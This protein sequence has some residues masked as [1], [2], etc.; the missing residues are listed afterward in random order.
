M[1]EKLSRNFVRKRRHDRL[2]KKLRG[3]S[4]CPR[5]SVYRSLKNVYAQLIDDEEGH[6][7]LTA[8]T[9]EDAV[10]AEGTMTEKAQKV[11][12]VLAER[13][14]EKGM[15]KLVFDRSG[16]KYHGRVAALADSLRDAGIEF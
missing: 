3:T 15:N 12:Q 14:K 7:L 13:M 4:E 8:S 5:L 2:R 9:L 6:T 11:G 10:G 16:Y 1:I